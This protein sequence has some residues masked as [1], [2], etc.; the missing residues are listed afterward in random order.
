[1]GAYARVNASCKSFQ[2]PRVD[3]MLTSGHKKYIAEA[4]RHHCDVFKICILL[5][6]LQFFF[7]P[8]SY[9]VIL[10]RYPI[11]VIGFRTGKNR[12]RQ[13]TKSN[14]A[15]YNSIKIVNT[16]PRGFYLR[17]CIFLCSESTRGQH[18]QSDSRSESTFRAGRPLYP[19]CPCTQT[20]GRDIDPLLGDKPQLHS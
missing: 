4:L 20:K 10:P 11:G 6:A 7:V 9:R 8:D 5:Y 19:S 2:G 18:R 1:M 3:S 14:R 15:R 17:R 16:S 13:G 12:L